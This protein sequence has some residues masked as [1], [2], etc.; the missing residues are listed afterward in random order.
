MENNLRNYKELKVMNKDQIERYIE[1]NKEYVFNEVSKIFNK[2]I[3]IQNFNG[4]IGGKNFTYNVK[5]E[6]YSTAKEYVEAWFKSFNIIYQKEKNY[7]E[8]KSSHRIYKLLQNPNIKEFI[9]IYLTR[10]YLRK[11]NKYN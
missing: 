8:E 3:N 9:S 10:T 1:N 6:N 11:T 2:E 5:P 7:S 4:I